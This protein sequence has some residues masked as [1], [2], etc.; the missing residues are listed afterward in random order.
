MRVSKESAVSEKTIERSITAFLKI[1]LPP[2]A[3]AFHV[4]NGGYRLSVG[5]LARLKASGYTAGIP[6]RCIL[7]QGRAYWLEAKGPRGTLTNS[8]NEMFPRIE[9]AGCP[10][11]VVRSV[12]DV[13]MA[14]MSWGI[15]IN[16]RMI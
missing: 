5:E 8:Q 9:R 7:W 11:V 16:A 15:P 13:Q 3:V 10:V 4:P 12:E 14:L 2:D 6:D 1:A